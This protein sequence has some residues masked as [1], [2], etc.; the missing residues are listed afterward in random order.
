MKILIAGDFYP[1][2]RVVELFKQGD[3]QTVLG[4]VKSVISDANYSIVNFECPVK[5]GGEAYN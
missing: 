2:D 3:F 1:Q 4:E 5:R